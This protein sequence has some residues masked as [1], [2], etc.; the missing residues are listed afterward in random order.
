MHSECIRV[1]ACCT[2]LCCV[3]VRHVLNYTVSTGQ[4][5]RLSVQ[6]WATGRVLFD[7][8]NDRGNETLMAEEIRLDATMMVRFSVWFFG[9]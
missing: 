1:R 3:A 4:W 8:R 5:F 9:A 2:C 7:L 6:Q